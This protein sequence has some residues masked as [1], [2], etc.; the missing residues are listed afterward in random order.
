MYV[1]YLSAIKE[2]V[3]ETV[4]REIT[5]ESPVWL[6]DILEKMI[7]QPEKL[8]VDFLSPGNSYRQTSIL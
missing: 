5:R 2:H 6:H 7:L 8:F 4:N 3:M 1:T